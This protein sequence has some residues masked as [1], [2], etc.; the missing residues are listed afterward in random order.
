MGQSDSDKPHKPSI[1]IVDDDVV[2]REIFRW[3]LQDRYNLTEMESGQGVSD[4]I[5]KSLPDLVFLDLRMPVV[6]GFDVVDE[7]FEQAP[8]TLK[9]VIVFSADVEHPR[10][11]NLLSMGIAGIHIRPYD[12]E[13]IH[14]LVSQYEQGTPSQDDNWI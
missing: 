3:A 1:L 14:A 5:Q 10:V 12:D 2:N 7:L 13:G 4:L 11:R 8:E 6:D 9:N